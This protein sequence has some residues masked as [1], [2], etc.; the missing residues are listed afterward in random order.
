M[1]KI[2]NQIN[3][4]KALNFVDMTNIY[5]MKIDNFL[6]PIVNQKLEQLQNLGNTWRVTTFN[7]FVHEKII[8]K[9]T[10]NYE[11]VKKDLKIWLSHLKLQISRIDALLEELESLE[12][13]G[14]G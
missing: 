7:N 4:N 11:E 2:E 9:F 6:I 12:K 13:G 5:D 10:K 8:E 1:G 14:E 3:I